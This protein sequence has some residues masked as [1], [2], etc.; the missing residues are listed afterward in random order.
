MWNAWK[1]TCESACMTLWEKYCVHGVH[2]VM[3]AM[4]ANFRALQ[5]NHLPF[6]FANVLPAVVHQNS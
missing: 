6:F 1:L 2:G 4:R 3:A 5:Q